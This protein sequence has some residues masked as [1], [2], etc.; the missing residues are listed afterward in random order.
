MTRRLFLVMLFEQTARS[1]ASWC[2][3]KQATDPKHCG[4]VGGCIMMWMMMVDNDDDDDDDDDD[5][6][7]EDDGDYGDDGDGE[8]IAQNVV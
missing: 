8:N 2:C 7:D 1:V 4:R 3:G 5:H 6:D